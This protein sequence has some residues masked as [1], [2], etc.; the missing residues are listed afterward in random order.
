MNAIELTAVEASSAMVMPVAAGARVVVGQY[1]IV[2]NIN[3][4]KWILLELDRG[5]K[6]VSV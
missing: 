6:Q 2:V 4:R 5:G 1:V 3:D